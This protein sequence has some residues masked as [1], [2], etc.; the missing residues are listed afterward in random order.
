M[1]NSSRR[2]HPLLLAQLGLSLIELMVGLTIGLILTLGLFTLIAGQSMTFK[3]QDDFARMQENATAALRYIGES[4]RMAGFYGYAQ[5]PTAINTVIGGVNTANDCGSATNFF[6]ANSNGAFD[7]G[8]DANW[9]LRVEV[10]LSGRANLT[11]AS[12]AGAFPCIA[13]A[14]FAG[15]PGANPNPILVTRGAAGYPIPDPNNDGNRS[16]GLALQPNF[17]NTVYLQSDP[18]TGLLFAGTSFAALRAAG[19]VTRFTRTGADFDIFEYRA[20]VYYLRPCSR[21]AGTPPPA[22]CTGATDDGGNP[23]PTLVRQELVGNRMTAVPLV[24]GVERIDY[25]YGIDDLPNPAPLGGVGDG[26]PDRFTATPA[27]ADWPNVVS[28]KVTVLVRAPSLTAGHNDA[29]KQYDLAGDGVLFDCTMVGGN[30]CFYKRTVFSQTFQV[31]N[32]AQRRGA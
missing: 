9:A 1:N 28:V 3:V 20:H 6:D 32:L 26:V 2:F 30:A 21:P 5:V 27:A 10:P 7:A 18:N 14:N 8:E 15:G 11:P 13:P 23:I 17:A 22:N 16:D 12:V 29:G 24:E 25:R 31:R 19:T 4:V